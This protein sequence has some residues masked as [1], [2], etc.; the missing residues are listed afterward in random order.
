MRLY[1]SNASTSRSQRR[2]AQAHRPMQPLALT[3]TSARRQEP[4][5]S[6]L[7]ES[8]MTLLSRRAFAWDLPA[9]GSIG[10]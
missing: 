5:L 10:G 1:A 7:T 8:T 6:R 9:S 3:G 2:W 4:A